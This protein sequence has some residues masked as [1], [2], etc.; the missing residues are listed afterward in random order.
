MFN[1]LL[2]LIIS[3]GIW[4]FLS[5]ILIYYIF[6]TQEKRDLKQDNREIK[7]QEIVSELGKRFDLI[8][9]DIQEI[10]KTLQNLKK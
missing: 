7:Y 2:E 6:N 9:L 5:F 10:K 1:E 3:Q 8:H 4:T